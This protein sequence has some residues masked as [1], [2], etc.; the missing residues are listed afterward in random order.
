MPTKTPKTKTAYTKKAKK[1][2]KDET[3]VPKTPQVVEEVIEPSSSLEDAIAEIW[4]AFVLRNIFN[5]RIIGKREMD[6]FK[7]YKDLARSII[8]A[9]KAEAEKVIEDTKSEDAA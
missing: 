2:T 8:D 6:I 7:R 3:I 9:K 4:D 5:P 1:E